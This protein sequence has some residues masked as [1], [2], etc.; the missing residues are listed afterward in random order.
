MSRFD[1]APWPTSLKVTSVAATALLVGASFAI[2]RAI[3]RGTGV[4][5]AETF[6]TLI[7]FV[8]P[9][10]AL[11]AILFIVTAYE[12]GPTELQVQRLLWSTRVPLEGIARAWIDPEA[13]KHSLRIFG[14]GGLY[15]VTGVYQNRLL[16]RY[17]A[18][19]TDPRRSVVLALPGRIV[20]V[21][22][23]DPGALV[24]QLALFHPSLRSNAGG[25]VDLNGE[26][27][28]RSS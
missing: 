7:A 26:P 4:P 16:G 22:P 8:P 11:T 2:I 21:S 23:A 24:E 25:R 5:F 27:R 20:V 12:V 13:M 17:R 3:P 14:N 6:G 28:G 19:V 18:F 10:T 15:S 1:A 9:L